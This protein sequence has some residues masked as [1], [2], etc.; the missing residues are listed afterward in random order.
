LGKI[1]FNELLL[2]S[3]TSTK[4]KD[5]GEKKIPSLNYSFYLSPQQK[6]KTFWAKIPSLN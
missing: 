1:S 2:L 4:I 6:E 3:L 5:T